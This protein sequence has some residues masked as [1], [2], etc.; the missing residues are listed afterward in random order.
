M[1]TSL[2]P[3]C[4]PKRPTPKQAGFIQYWKRELE[5][6]S[7][8]QIL[9]FVAETFRRKAAF[10]TSSCMEDSV[11]GFLLE[12]IKK[13][14]IFM[15]DIAHLLLPELWASTDFHETN[16][17]VVY[18][19]SAGNA[20]W[21]L[22]PLDYQCQ[23]HEHEIGRYAVWIVGTRREQHP[24]FARMPIIEWNERF[25]V[26]RIA[27]LARWNE[28]SIKDII[29]RERIGMIGSGT[30]ETRENVSMFSRQAGTDGGVLE[31]NGMP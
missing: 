18:G 30:V 8:I 4:V 5:K 3:L 13:S 1:N 27:P 7:S 20:M 19:R 6:M 15:D 25:G 23:R 2:K 26:F 29:R 10:A 11:V 16:Q 24:A 31:S 21:S 28:R 9:Q 17:E 14:L 12:K 22:C